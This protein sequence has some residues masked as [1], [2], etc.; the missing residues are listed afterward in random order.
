MRLQEIEARLAA[1][2]K[3]IEERGAELTAEQL[4]AFTKEVDD[5]KT[6]RAGLLAAA[7]QRSSLLASMAEGTSGGAVVRSFPSP[8]AP[9]G[10]EQRGEADPLD[11]MEYRRA[12]MDYA[13]RGT[14][15]PAEFRANAVSTTADNG[16]AIPTTTLNKIIEKM[17]A[18][19]MILPLVTRTA[20]KGGV[21]IPTS[22]EACCDVGCRGRGERQAEEGHGKHYLCLPQVAV[23]RGRVA[24]SGRY[25]L[26]RV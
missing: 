23:R 4:A 16:A 13:L 7:E 10:G 8:A 5:L 9:A 26:V 25:G 6:E 22:S 18:V 19:G 17:E 11:S 2:K 24:G 20:Y 3:E 21:S 15:I 1:I 14:P 12:F